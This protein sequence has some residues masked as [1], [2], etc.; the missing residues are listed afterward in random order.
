MNLADSAVFRC[1]SRSCLFPLRRLAR[2]VA[3]RQQDLRR[4][5]AC[6]ERDV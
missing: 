5:R 2:L 6:D 1:V 4:G 3:R